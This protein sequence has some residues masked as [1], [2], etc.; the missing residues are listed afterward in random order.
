MMKFLECIDFPCFHRV[1]GSEEEAEERGISD[2]AMSYLDCLGGR[3]LQWNSTKSS[4]ILTL[5]AL[6]CGFINKIYKYKDDKL[7][8]N[9][10][11]ADKK[12]HI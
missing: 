12:M 7:V 3:S 11:S 5:K 4:H 8:P 2:V 10:I 1:I 9:Y 6:P